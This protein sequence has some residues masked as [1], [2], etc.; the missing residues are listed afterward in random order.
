M[1]ASSLDSL[2]FSPDDFEFYNGHYGLHIIEFP[3]PINDS[4]TVVVDPQKSPRDVAQLLHRPGQ[5]ASHDG[6]TTMKLLLIRTRNQSTA[7][8]APSLPSV[9]NNFTNSPSYPQTIQGRRDAEFIKDLFNELDLPLAAYAAYIKA[10]ITFICAPTFQQQRQDT[11]NPTIQRTAFYCS[12]T[13]WTVAWSYDSIIKHTVA[14]LFYREGDGDQRKDE[15]IQDL[16]RLQPHLSHPMLLG[17]IKTKVSLSFTFTMLDDMNRETMALEQEIGFPT[18]N[19]ILDRDIPGKGVSETQDQAVEGFNILSGKLTNI[20]FRLKTFQQQIKFISRC[21]NQHRLSLDPLSPRFQWSL[22]ECDELDHFMNVMWDYTFI[23]LFDA[24]SLGERLQNA[25]S[26][27]F[28]LTTQRDSR[29]SLAV[30]DIN[31]ELAWQGK[32]TNKAMTTIAFVS[33]LFLPGTFVA[34]FFDAPIFNFNM[35]TD[36]NQVIVPLPF[37]AFWSVSVVLT[38]TL[39]VGWISYLRRSKRIGLRER[40][41]ERQQLGERIRTRRVGGP[42]A[43]LLEE[44]TPTIVYDVE[45]KKRPSWNCIEKNNNNHGNGVSTDHFQRTRRLLDFSPCWP[46]PKQPVTP[47]DMANLPGK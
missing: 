19:F 6:E 9:P 18:W 5:I 45:S 22:R 20:R 11:N 30:A 1:P 16:L 47:F 15:V 17:F 41:L 46:R 25:M 35:P 44:R 42:V 32:N 36:E 8:K 14:V 40:D 3:R 7:K 21:N 28:Q 24:D 38:L 13:S 31:N 33:L 29:A 37:W 26:S 2:I 27:V 10:H 43:M 39:V 23:H 34:S 4:T 12:G